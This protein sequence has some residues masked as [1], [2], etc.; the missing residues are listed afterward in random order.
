[1]YWICQQEGVGGADGQDQGI[2]QGAQAGEVSIMRVQLPLVDAQ[3][4]VRYLY[5]IL[6]IEVH[7]TVVRR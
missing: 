3:G 4:G 1:M 5:E 6:S 2:E 7:S